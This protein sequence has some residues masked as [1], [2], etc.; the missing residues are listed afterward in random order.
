MAYSRRKAGRSRPHLHSR[1]SATVPETPEQW[2]SGRD[3]ADV[4][5][6]DAVVTEA[7]TEVSPDDVLRVLRSMPQRSRQYVLSVLGLRGAATVNRGMAAQLLA[8]ARAE[9][10]AARGEVLRDLT[11]PLA[12]TLDHSL[13]PKLWAALLGEDNAPAVAVFAEHPQ[14]AISLN[15]ALRELP[16][17]LLRAGLASAIAWDTA[18]SA[19]A[20]AVMATAEE[21]ARQAHIQLADQFPD[22]P[23]VPQAKL[24]EL[25]PAARLDS[26]GL[27]DGDLLD[28]DDLQQILEEIRA[29]P[30]RFPVIESDDEAAEDGHDFEDLDS[31][32]DDDGA[33][34]AS[35]TAGDNVASGDIPADDEALIA[36]S[37]RVLAQ[38]ETAADAA[39]SVAADMR[40]GRLPDD[41][42]LGQVAT[43]V[44]AAFAALRGLRQRIDAE[45]L[46]ESRAGIEE[47]I[48][49]LRAELAAASDAVWL[50]RLAALEGHES[51]RTTIGQVRAAAAA[52]LGDPDAPREPL[53][54]LLHVLDLIAAQRRGELSDFATVA[55][56]QGAA[57]TLWPETA[58]LFTA[59]AMGYVTLPDEVAAKIEGTAVV[60]AT[61]EDDSPP[62]HVIDADEE[63][64]TD[65]TGATVA[66][67]VPAAVAPE[68]TDEGPAE[69]VPTAEISAEEASPSESPTGGAL[70]GAAEIPPA[71]EP[72]PADAHTAERTT[73][74]QDETAGEAGTTAETSADLDKWAGL[75]EIDLTELDAALLGGAGAALA[76]VG[77]PRRRPI[78]AAAPVAGATSTPDVPAEALPAPDVTSDGRADG[79]VAAVVST[80]LTDRRFGLAADILEAAGAAP[81]AV[82]ARRLAAYADALT[83]PTGPL[84]SAF[85]DLI[86]E[87]TRE[88]LADDRAGQLLAL[89]AAARVAL[90]APSA[91]PASVLADLLPC[92]S[93]Q[94]ALTEA[95]D[96]L[97]D[98]SRAGIV[99]VAETADAVGTLAA[100]EN[101][102]ADAARAAA[103]MLTP[104][105]RRPIK[106]V[107]A[108]GVYGAWLN[109]DGPLGTLLGMVAAND[110]AAVLDVRNAVV[111]LR[112]KAAKAID[113]TFTEI[114]RQQKRQIKAGARATLL[115]RWEEALELAVRWADAA[116]QV[117]QA[118][119]VSA[120]AWQAAPLNK[121]RQRLA[122][123]RVA[124]AAE[125]AAQAG[126]T[127]VT[128]ATVDA[129]GQLLADA[130][131]ICDG[132]APGGDEP[133]VAYT[134]HAE[135]LATD[136]PLTAD[137]LLPDTGLT[138]DTLPALLA[139]AAEAPDVEA[140]Y[141]G[142]AARGDH[143]L[144]AVL[145]AGLRAEDP[146]TAA[147]LDRQRAAD[148][149]EMTGV[150]GDEVSALSSLIDARRMA[151]TLDDGPWATLASRARALDDNAR[152]D[153]GRIRAAAAGIRAELDQHQQRKIDATLARIAEHAQVSTLV[154]EAAEKLSAWAREGHVASAEEHLQTT[155]A[156]HRLPQ[157]R[158]EPGHLQRFFPAVPD[159]AARHPN[160][161][162]ELHVALSG[163]PASSGV[164]GL[165]GAGLDVTEL[166][167]VRRDAARKAIGAWQSALTGGRGTQR[168]VELAGALRLV[169]SQ[170]G[171]EF[172][173][174]RQH[175]SPA[176][177]GGRQWLTLHRV[178]GYGDALTPALGSGMSTDGTTLRVLLVKSAP[179]PTT[180]LEW[181]SSEAGDQ[182]VLVLWTGTALSAAQRRA[183]ANAARGRAKPPL[184]WLDA[185]AL[186]YLACQPE[187]R[188]TTFEA[189]ALPFSAASPYR[190][191]PG[192]TPKEMFYGRTEELAAVQ[193]LAGPSFVSGGRQLG[194]SALLREAARRFVESGTARHAVMASLFTVGG[195]GHPER[196]WQTLW[197]DLHRAGI[198]GEV[199]ASQD[200]A[201]EV[202]AAV[203]RWLEGNPSRAL[204]V[205]L[206]EADAF[207]EA[208]A[209][210][211]LFPNVDR[212]RRIM[213]ES[214]RRVKFVFAGLHRTARFESLPNQPLAHLGRPIVVGPLRPQHAHELLTE[215]LGALGFGFADPDTLPARILAL[216]NNMPALLQLFGEAL[217][218]HM[219]AQP[220]PADGPPQ[221]VTAEDVEVVF[222]D[223]DLRAAYRDKYVL[224]LNLDHR[225][226]VV[227]Y[228]VAA[229]AHEHGIDAS[230]SLSELSEECRAY[231]PAGFA[232][233][234]ADDFR[235]LVTECVDLGVLAADGGRYRLRTPSVLRLLGTEEEVL[236]TLLSAPDRLT[237]P[238]VSDAGSHRRPFGE[239]GRSPLTERQ[240]GRLFDARRQVLAV[241][242]SAALGVGAV[243][244]AVEAAR[245]GGR[246][247]GALTR[248]H[249][250]T[251]D[252]IRV[253]VARAA[254]DATLVLADATG[255]SAEA[256]A[257]LFVA[258]ET[259]VAAAPVEVTVAVVCAPGNAPA[260]VRRTERIDS[261]RVD[262]PGLRLWCDQ[263]NLPFPDESSRF[264][265][266]AV[267]G[268]WPRVLAHTAARATTGRP[269]PG[270]VRLLE[271]TAAWL[272]GDAG[273]RLIADAGIGENSPA[274]RAV[275]D[276]AAELTAETGEQPDELAA[277]LADDADLT[278]LAASAGFTGVGEVIDTLLALS[279]LA[280]AADGRVQAEPVLAAAVARQAGARA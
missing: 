190:D 134:A 103:N 189:I 192:D 61:V 165:V 228:A 137:T 208:D 233:C 105:G 203:L 22:L 182:T 278:A 148:I 117:G 184:L 6:L 257:V 65:A 218:R 269:A 213:L 27:A 157:A 247:L 72:V 155:L 47:G 106:Y 271:D 34:P 214:E 196:L 195:D 216:A 276:A 198:V 249:T 30:D 239:A 225:Y 53:A 183:I 250:V 162:A 167:D 73:P 9:Q 5:D 100:A 242:G 263:D 204:L 93:D 194:K 179:S 161:L 243:I 237:V 160:L 97:A 82:A 24:A 200:V 20:L 76:A 199:P 175:P 26:M 8:R 152:R 2:P 205:L 268:G 67:E 16:P 140:V 98:A 177:Q 275:F 36:S 121:L 253:E 193:D 224:T 124:A 78:P 261:A 133:P 255:C 149:T 211:A 63:P 212:C 144:T 231:W 60:E 273:Q 132:D 153:Y 71:D 222:A 25:A 58:A 85:A 129:A 223:A 277:V 39:D 109:P 52:A 66:P 35:A 116:E 99:V 169:L 90:L 50:R 248:C 11:A 215:P 128:A 240:L 234:G 44:T 62:D 75:A 187:P 170:A 230:L 168:S 101:D 80:L 94:S 238:S 191:T 29:L 135:L 1:P 14:L 18:A 138:A 43:H 163:G 126:D 267:T 159:V 119:A 19:V 156:G 38:W 92:V 88:K 59:A 147:A 96:A 120:G 110:P 49:A 245:S 115:A 235:G 102:A 172:G 54:A 158:T 13:G 150:V 7:L 202:H 272:A 181:M 104:A 246:W 42:T 142:R 127:P 123:V 186:A 87:V 151:G 265:L 107:P 84:A 201:E 146:A 45:Q 81:A 10:P 31:Q 143:D 77:A 112:G 118:A 64:T 254:T 241:T 51:V 209:V 28:G 206:D 259:A 232:S 274:L 217:M 91:S 70:P 154:A 136:L 173:D 56:A 37:E 141:A 131:A 108:N 188:R 252:G 79:D 180:V 226:L 229:A 139:V 40:A 113:T 164:A 266:A 244:P 236:E 95:L 219:A 69:E 221:L 207:L 32:G 23:P 251:P 264:R 171:L 12:A 125:L 258:A 145:A 3:I 122:A 55:E 280:V 185:G 111:S 270:A 17:A 86:G 15:L 83:E 46:P 166:P 114:N 89:T 256:L 68:L 210:D 178:S 176:G 197:P 262:I 227:A 57:A 21:A 174:V 74:V 33:V 4:Y 279:C 260:W 41:A 220:V 130:F 48:A